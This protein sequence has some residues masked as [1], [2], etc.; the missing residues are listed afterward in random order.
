MAHSNFQFSLKQILLLY[1]LGR[2]L[3]D[4]NSAL[5]DLGINHKSKVMLIGKKVSYFLLF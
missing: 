3:N 2:T 4:Y 1:F 5:A